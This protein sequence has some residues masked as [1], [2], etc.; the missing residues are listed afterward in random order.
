MSLLLALVLAVLGGL[1]HTRTI[2]SLSTLCA[3]FMCYYNIIRF[4]KVVKHRCQLHNPKG[5]TP[6]AWK[7]SFTYSVLPHSDLFNFWKNV[8]FC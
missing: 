6:S 5:K 8:L 2:I 7:S 4:V 1:Q 3:A